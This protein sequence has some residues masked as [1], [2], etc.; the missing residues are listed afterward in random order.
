MSSFCKDKKRVALINAIIVV[1]SAFVW[2]V[3]RYKQKQSKTIYTIKNIK[4]C[5]HLSLET[6][7]LLE[8]EWKDVTSTLHLTLLQSTNTEESKQSKED[9]IP[10][11]R[12]L[13]KTCPQSIFDFTIIEIVIGHIYLKESFRDIT[14]DKLKKMLKVKL[15]IN[16]IKDRAKS[17]GIDLNA[18]IFYDENGNLT[19]DNVDNKDKYSSIREIYIGSLLIHPSY[20]RKGFAKLLL[21]ES[22]L[23]VNTLGYGKLTGAAKKELIAF[24]T[25]LGGKTDMK[26]A[27]KTNAISTLITNQMLEQCKY[28]IQNSKYNLVDV[29]PC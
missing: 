27:F 13:I 26:K 14:I 20:R 3:Y 18:S 4:Q 6:A 19:F 28:T 25:H 24:Y 16:A 23:F 15:P 11:N 8:S 2:T 10:C 5:S 1:T 9:N 29:T 7:E 12:I 17:A 21:S 22:L